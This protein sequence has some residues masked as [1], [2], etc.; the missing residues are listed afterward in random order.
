MESGDAAAGSRGQEDSMRK[1]IRTTA[2]A[3]ALTAALALA[4]S[5]AGAV[6]Y[7]DS[8]DDCSYPKLF[9]AALMRPVGLFGLIGGATGLALFTVTIIGPAMVNRDYP[10]VARLLVVP[11]AKFTFARRLGECSGLANDY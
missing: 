7:E 3:L 2:A 10:E 11:A 6:G 1:L 5:R 4:P 8:L 9:D